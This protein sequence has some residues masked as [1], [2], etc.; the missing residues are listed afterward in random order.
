LVDRSVS[1]LFVCN[2]SEIVLQILDDVTVCSGI[3]I[4]GPIN[5]P[6]LTDDQNDGDR[7]DNLHSVLATIQHTDGE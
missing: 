3:R 4:I 2:D 5:F 7:G 1:F 6:S